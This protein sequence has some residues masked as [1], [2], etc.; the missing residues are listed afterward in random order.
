MARLDIQNKTA[1]K[2]YSKTSKERQDAQRQQLIADYWLQGITSSYRISDLLKDEH[3]IKVS[4][5]KVNQDL[6]DVQKKMLETTID[7]VKAKVLG[8]YQMLFNE[9]I[10]AWFESKH[11]IVTTTIKNGTGAKGDWEE[12]SE[13]RT[14]QTGNP[15]HWANAEKSLDAIRKLWGLDAPSEIEVTVKKELDTL[16]DTLESLMP[17]T[18]YQAIMESLLAEIDKE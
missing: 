12:F 13:K 8:A 3:G 9:A 15:S 1:S 7:E 5:W 2:A 14:P 17:E 10:A 4:P 18:Q 16:L 11:D 6:N